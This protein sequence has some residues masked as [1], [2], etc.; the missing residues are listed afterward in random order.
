MAETPLESYLATVDPRFAPTV[1]ALADA[2]SVADPSLSS[3]IGYRMLMYA[4]GSRK[5]EWICAIGTSSKAAHLRFL[6][7]DLLDD[8][9]GVLRAGTSTLKTIDV[10][11]AEHVDRDL[12]IAYVREAVAKHPA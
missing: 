5:R 11:S 2:L 1:R 3:W 10:T 7:G 9:A 6:H 8:P 12:V 4:R